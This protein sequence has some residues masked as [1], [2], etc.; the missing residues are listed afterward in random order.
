MYVDERGSAQA[1]IRPCDDEGRVRGPWLR[2]LPPETPEQATADGETRDREQEENWVGWRA[3]GVHT[4]ADVP[5]FSPLEGWKAETRGPQ[6]LR[7]G[8]DYLLTIGDPGDSYVYNG[9]VTF[10][11]RELAR[12][13]PGKVLTGDGPMSRDAFEQRAQ[14]EC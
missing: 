12:L 9:T 6:I 10:D 3:R 4:A 13:S 14:D 7:P 11:A 1:L 2:G 8:Y 5:L